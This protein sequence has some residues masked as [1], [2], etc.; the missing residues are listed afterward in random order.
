MQTH[1]NAGSHQFQPLENE[2]WVKHFSTLSLIPPLEFVRILHSFSNYKKPVF[3]NSLDNIP[4]HIALDVTF[5]RNAVPPNAMHTVKQKKLCSVGILQGITPV[6]YFWGVWL[7]SLVC[8]L[9]GFLAFFLVPFLGDIGFGLA[10]SSLGNRL[11]YL[12]GEEKAVIS[13]SSG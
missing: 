3:Y 11:S 1:S 4:M 10:V 2:N 5:L 6:L 9:A 13:I 8:L 7:L 12:T